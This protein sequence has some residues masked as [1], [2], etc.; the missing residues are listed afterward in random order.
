[1]HPIN[2][3]ELNEWAKKQVE[4]TIREAQQ[5]LYAQTIAEQQTKPRFGWLRKLLHKTELVTTQTGEL[6]NDL[7]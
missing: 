6:M 2:G 7:S 3:L 4:R 5:N 1:M